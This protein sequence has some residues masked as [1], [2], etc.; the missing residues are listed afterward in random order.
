MEEFEE[1]VRELRLAEQALLKQALERK[2]DR[3]RELE[4]EATY[5]RRLL[6]D[7]MAVPRVAVAPAAAAP[8]RRGEMPRRWRA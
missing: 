7:A 4:A 1:N 2:D 3:I 6:N 8:A 5:L